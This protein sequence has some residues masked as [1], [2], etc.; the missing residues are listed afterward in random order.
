MC[1]NEA[2]GRPIPAGVAGVGIDSCQE[3]AIALVHTLGTR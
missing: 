2:Q 3:S 1:P